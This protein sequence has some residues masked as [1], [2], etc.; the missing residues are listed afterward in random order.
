MIYFLDISLC[1]FLD[2]R[3]PGKWFTICL[4][5]F[6]KQ[7]FKNTFFG[8]SVLLPELSLHLDLC[9]QLGGVSV[10]ETGMDFVSTV[11]GTVPV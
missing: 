10:L 2:L 8:C 7:L 5:E 11:I 4:T 6:F 1:T 3:N 9:A